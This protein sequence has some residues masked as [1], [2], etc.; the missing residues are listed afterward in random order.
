MI[1][2]GKN[3]A[4]TL[5]EVLITLGVI[6]IVA[7]LTL[8]NMIANHRKKVVA[9]QLE[10]SYA[11][12][13]Q[14]ISMAIA[15][16]GDPSGWDYY[17]KG[18]TYG[19]NDILEQWVNTYM[20]PYISNIAAKGKCTVTKCFGIYGYYSP[21]YD[22][23]S[24]SAN[25]R[26]PMYMIVKGGSSSIAWAVS[27]FPGVYSYATIVHVYLKNPPPPIWPR[28][29]KDVFTFIFDRR[30]KNPRF[31]P[32]IPHDYN[33]PVNYVYRNFTRDDLLNPRE[34][35]ACQTGA[36][37]WAYYNAGEACSALIM[38]DGWKINDDY[39]FKF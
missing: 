7:A 9:V 26:M 37:D 27:R 28:N 22:A 3:K 12:L 13:N 18:D 11:E 2:L 16:H 20:T 24:N 32:Y 38:V 4:F 31:R 15:E 1:I 33:P 5:A 14:V 25:P 17:G 29:G 34:N 39:P 8:P 21:D 10:K 36:K 23:S 30:E 19:E 6:G 35:A